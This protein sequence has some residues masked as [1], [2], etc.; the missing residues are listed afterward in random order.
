MN[1][2]NGC[3]DGVEVELERA[4]CHLINMFMLLTASPSS[5][6]GA[7]LRGKQAQGYGSVGTTGYPK[8]GPGAELHPFLVVKLHQLGPHG[9]GRSSDY[10]AGGDRAGAVPVLCCLKAPRTAE[11]H[12]DVK[13]EL[14]M[15][16]I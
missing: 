4:C 2:R 10:A 3:K 16:K 1:L 6:V 13:T 9:P 14:V 15:M 7:I 8:A 12:G 11:A 5:F